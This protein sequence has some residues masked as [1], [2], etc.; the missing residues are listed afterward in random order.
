M[1]AIIG[2]SVIVLLA[3]GGSAIALAAVDSGSAAEACGCCGCE[4]AKAEKDSKA[5]KSFATPPKVGTEAICPVMGGKF[6][7]TKDT[8]RSEYKGRHYVFCCP[9]CKPKFDADPGKYTK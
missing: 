8:E 5:K 2:L 6:K 3:F 1:K 4:K 7:V 9:G